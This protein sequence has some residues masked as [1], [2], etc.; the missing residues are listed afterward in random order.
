M[1][2]H[3]CYETVDTGAFYIGRSWAQR[4]NTV[5]FNTFDTVR[6]T[7]RLAQKSCSQ[8]AFYLDDRAKPV[9]AQSR[10]NLRVSLAYMLPAE[11]K[12]VSI[13]GADNG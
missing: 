5:R 9:H 10:Y 13:N 12:F 7:E 6:A 4:G 1:L 11:R 2:R 3:I 8:N